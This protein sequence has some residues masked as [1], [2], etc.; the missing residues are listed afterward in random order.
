MLNNV[1]FQL[2]YEITFV[3]IVLLSKNRNGVLDSLDSKQKNQYNWVMVGGILAGIISL[4]VDRSAIGAVVS[5]V[6]LTGFI[7]IYEDE[8]TKAVN[9][10][11]LRV[12]Y[13]FTNIASYV[14]INNTPELAPYKMFLI[15]YFVAFLIV[16]LFFSGI[17]PSDARMF[18][19]VC[20]V[21]V[22]LFRDDS[23]I[24]LLAIIASC[25]AYQQ[26]RQRLEADPLLG[27]P[28]ALPIYGTIF[29]LIAYYAINIILS[30]VF[31]I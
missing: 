23:L 6:L 20:P 8:S 13:L 17:G 3:L 27:V 26:F 9:R 1:F 12:G 18:M 31:T 30:S 19:L 14:I 25:T 21:L 2:F 4:A 11:M 28:M 16:L 15:V 22:L 7:S 10:N 29:V 5:I 24:F